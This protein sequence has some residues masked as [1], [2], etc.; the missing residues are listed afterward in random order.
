MRLTA[1]AW[2]RA[3]VLAYLVRTG[4]PVTLHTIAGGLQTDHNTAHTALTQL[5]ELGAL[6]RADLPMRGRG[7]RRFTYRAAPVVRMASR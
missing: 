7:P 4:L 6:D 3:V 1:E 5:E 2:R